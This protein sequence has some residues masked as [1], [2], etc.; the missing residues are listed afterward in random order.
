M[1]VDLVLPVRNIVGESLVWDDRAQRLF[2]VDIV[3]KTLHALDPES[4]HSQN[5]ETPDF[6][7]SIGLRQDGGAIVGLTKTVC[8]WDYDDRFEPLALIEPDMPGNRLNEGVVGPDGA[9]WIGTMQNNIAP[10]GSPMDMTDNTGRLY[11]CTPKG[12]IVAISEDRFGLTNTLI[13]T[14]DGRLVTADTAANEIYSYAVEPGSGTLSDR[15]TILSGFERGLPDGSCLDAE[16]FIW[17]CRVV[18]GACLVRMSPEGEID[19][20]VDLPCSWPT[21]CTFGGTELDRLYVT[22][23]RFTMDSDHLAKHPHEG[24]LFALDVGLT[25]QKSNRFGMAAGG[26]DR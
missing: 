25:G 1:A 3:G 19:R 15:R 4:G 7:T 13:W 16:G 5:W 12:E 26:T 20:I 22:S 10:D 14:G 18:G 2:W 21:S 24:G 8:L 11:R 6:V 9:F 17:N 23:A